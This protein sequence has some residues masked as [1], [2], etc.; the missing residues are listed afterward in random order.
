M[1]LKKGFKLLVPELFSARR[2]S[3]FGEHFVTQASNNV[4]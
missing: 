4:W 1:D 3:K 2:R